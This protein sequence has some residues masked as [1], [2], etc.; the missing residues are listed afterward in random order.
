MRSNYL[1]TATTFAITAMTASA[2]IATFTSQ[3]SMIGNLTNHANFNSLSA[4]DSLDLYVEDGVQFDYSRDYFSWNPQGFDGSEMFYANTGTFERVDIS[5]TSGED[6]NDVDMQVSSG[7]SPTQMGTMYLWVQLLDDGQ[8]VSEFDIDATTGEYVGFT[9]GG[10][11]QILIGSYQ[12]AVVR[13]SHDANA[14]NTIA[15]DNLS[16]GTFVPAPG[17]LMLSGIT[18]LGLSRRRR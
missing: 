17:A 8:L 3:T 18:M 15:L 6:F 5:L 10:F 1:A 11:D 16:A 2:G 14:R 9:G 7:W 13:D 12:S 4:G